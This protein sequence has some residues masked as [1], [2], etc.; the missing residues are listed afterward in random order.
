MVSPV[1]TRHP[2][3]LL[4]AILALAALP[5]GDAHAGA[6]GPTVERGD[7]V[8]VRVSIADL[9]LA[10]EAGARAAL[11]RVTIAA[12][13]VCSPAPAITE[14]ER[15]RLYK[16]CIAGKVSKAVAD[17]GSPLMASLAHPVP[18]TLAGAGR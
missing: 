7:D 2:K 4:A 16:A 3:T 6:I 8:T 17:I 13:E 10:T 12:R 18:S 9:N 15:W 14:L 11:S 5:L 1:S